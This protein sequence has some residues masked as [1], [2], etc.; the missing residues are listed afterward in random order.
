MV[1]VLP[2]FACFQYW[3]ESFVCFALLS[4]F[5]L[6]LWLLYLVLHAV[7]VLSMYVSVV[8]V[9][10]VALYTIA[11]CR[12]LPCRGQLVLS[13]QL[14]LLVAVFVA[15]VLSILLLWSEIIDLI[16]TQTKAHQ[17]QI[18]DAPTC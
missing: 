8:S 16:Q 14:H 2:C 4:F 11:S 3:V 10:M 18:I 1:G 9:L 7:Y 5:M 15:S 17:Q 6:V 12:Q 13:L